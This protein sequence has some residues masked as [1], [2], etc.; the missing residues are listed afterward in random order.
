[1]IVDIIVFSSLLFGVAF[2]LAWLVSPRLRQWIEKPKYGFQANVQNY[3]R[4]QR[5]RK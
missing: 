1:M 5:S 3:D 2:F 4:M